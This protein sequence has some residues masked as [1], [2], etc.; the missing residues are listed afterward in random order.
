MAMAA[1]NP[2]IED[3]SN[4]SY[5][6]SAVGG[7]TANGSDYLAGEPAYVSAV[8]SALSS[9]YALANGIQGFQAEGATSN[10]ADQTQENAL[11]GQLTQQANG[12]GAVQD[13]YRAQMQRGIQSQVAGQ[14]SLANSNR[15]GN[16]ALALRGAQSNGAVA[17]AQ[18]ANQTAQ[19]VAQNELAANS[20]LGSVAN[21][22]ATQQQ[23]NN[24][25]NAQLG[26]ANGQYNANN[27]MQ[28]QQLQ[29]NIYQSL[30]RQ[31]L[32][33][34][35]ATYQAEQQAEQYA[36]GLNSQ[37]NGIAQGVGVANNAT[38]MAIGGAAASA[39]GALIG[40]LSSGSGSS[41]ATVE[42][43]PTAVTVEG[44]SSYDGT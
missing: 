21:T 29:Q 30:I 24:Q 26:Q 12:T 5:T 16:L 32:S 19:G 22:M 31:G 4:N 41:D 40:G 11:L 42:Q 8:N 34:E 44:G 10:G 14:Q 2:G 20:Q 23:T 35:Q 33:A 39:G 37:S 18:G 9:G 25:F 13:A 38:G 15:N 1:N 43:A 17:Q 28:A 6:S 7:A 36:A 3:V 27:Q